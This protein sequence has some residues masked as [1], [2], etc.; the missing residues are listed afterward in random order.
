MTTDQDR[1]ARRTRI[2]GTIG[3][4][5]R[6]EEVLRELVATGLDVAR[7]NF[8]HESHPVHQASI[9][10]LRAV[11]AATGTP[12]AILQ[13]LCGPKLRLGNLPAPLQLEQGDRIRFS[14][15]GQGTSVDDIP[16]PAQRAFMAIAPGHRLLMDDG[17][18]EALV[19]SRTQDVIEAE[20][21]VSGV[22]SARK[23]V[24]LPDTQIP[25]ASVTD[26]DLDDLRFG[27]EHGVD[28]VAVS[29]VRSPADLAPVRQI[30]RESGS[31]TRLLAKIEKREAVQSLEE[32]LAVVDGV[33]IARGDLGVEMPIDEVPILQKR[34]I[35]RCNQAQKLVIT[36]T[37]MLES[38]MTNP[39]PT[40]AEASDVANSII[41]GTD[42]VMLS[43]ETAIGAYPVKAVEVMSRIAL[44]AERSIMHHSRHPVL[45]ESGSQTVT[46]GVAEAIWHLAHG[47]GIRAIVCLTQS[48][49]TAQLVSKHR[50]EAP[51]IALTPHLHTC[52]QLALAWGVR[53][54]LCDEVYETES[55]LRMAAHTVL[56]SGVAQ[57]G[58]TILITA[59]VPV[60][61]PGRTNLIKVHTL[62][63]PL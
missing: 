28:W 29:F 50:P 56:E 37:Q 58:D 16:F 38:M 61:I 17:K 32:I 30:I 3:P 21:V 49:G 54:I 46:Q 9:E 6:S 63:D 62:G 13:D 34:I 4:S 47:I 45:P 44:Q 7:L 10:R 15:S 8:S 1:Y 25:V 55:M 19:I 23:G 52:R 39:R 12:I 41:D 11:E 40:R 24:N 51:I 31:R 18:V 60:G 2:I 53:P 57:R 36:A 22:I 20:V 27:I 59:G 43:G 14:P 35:K 26:K 48:G 5:C 42:A 33:M